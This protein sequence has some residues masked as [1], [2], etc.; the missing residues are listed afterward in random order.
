MWGAIQ[1]IVLTRMAVGICAIGPLTAFI[2][3][4]RIHLA[5]PP[6]A[7]PPDALQGVASYSVDPS[8]GEAMKL[9]PLAIL[10]LIP[11]IRRRWSLREAPLF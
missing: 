1:L 2:Q 4:S 7:M 8:I 10:M 3:L 9:L 6:F 5:A 11:A